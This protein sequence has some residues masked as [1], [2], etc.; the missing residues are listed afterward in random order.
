MSRAKGL[1]SGSEV[2]YLS[3]SSGAV[4]SASE[5]LPTTSGGQVSQPSGSESLTSRLRES[6]RQARE[7]EADREAAQADA[8]A[9]AEESL[10]DPSDP[11]TGPI[12]AKLEMSEAQDLE[13]ATDLQVSDM[14]EM[15]ERQSQAAKFAATG[16]LR[17][18]TQASQ[19]ARAL[20]LRALVASVRLSTDLGGAAHSGLVGDRDCE[21]LVTDLRMVCSQCCVEPELPP[22]AEELV[23]RLSGAP[24]LTPEAQMELSADRF[25]DLLLTRP[26]A[27][28]PT[29]LD[30]KLAA[31][32]R[33]R[34][35][36]DSEEVS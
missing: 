36:E 31:L 20:A 12:A 13:D 18:W 8:R 14:L 3:G 28:N 25:L 5:L 26:P 30:V 23:L 17:L 4:T 15:D 9:A 22:R 35:P 33:D 34:D 10:V 11:R 6:L 21:H 19:D 7:A 29:T 1:D 27:K 24:P 32:L 2:E 16:V